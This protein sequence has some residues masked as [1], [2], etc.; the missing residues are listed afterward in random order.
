MF[1]GSQT[2]YNIIGR[3]SHRNLGMIDGKQ[4]RINTVGLFR[5]FNMLFIV[6][7]HV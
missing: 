7:P 2:L 4:T 1:H 3:K 5:A 6:K